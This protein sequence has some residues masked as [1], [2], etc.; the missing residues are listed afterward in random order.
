MSD[1]QCELVSFTPPLWRQR[2]LFILDTLRTHRASSVLDF[3]CGE[4]S[5]LAFLI[6]SPPSS[7]DTPFT[8]LA[9]IDIDSECVEEAVGRCQPWSTDH[10]E[11]RENPLTIDI[12]HGSIGEVDSR[13]SG[14][15]AIVCSEVVEHVYPDVLAT[16]FSTT[17]GNYMPKIMIVTTPNAEYNIHFPSLHYGQ[18]NAEFRHD[19]HKFEWTRQE[20]EDW[21]KTGADAYGYNYSFEG[22]GLLDNKKYDSK[23]G[24]CTQACIF[25]R[26]SQ[27]PPVVLSTEHHH[28]LAAHIEFPFY[29]KPD[30]SKE[31][32]KEI[33]EHYIS[34]MCLSE[35]EHEQRQEKYARREAADKDEVL[36]WCV[37]WSD[38]VIVVP[39]VPKAS[40]T[41]QWTRIPLT[42]SLS[43]LW[44]ILEIRQAFKKYEAM[45]QLLQDNPT[46]YT[47]NNENLTVQKSFEIIRD[48]SE[49]ED[50]E[51]IWI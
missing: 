29:N 6:P 41:R 36:E 1:D 4:A 26:I 15:E 38:Q 21:C 13:L 33:I 46:E 8:R 5:V 9:G 39:E 31:S 30:L 19:D 20:F 44:D 34:K 37:D 28:R 27:T 25:T 24:H 16:F 12:F 48:D 43:R 32:Q 50:E 49:E 40:P 45:V 22:I 11:L 2:R 17:L 18:P 7:D 42:I 35:E 51:E 3:G 10:T 23:V 47:V 14:Y